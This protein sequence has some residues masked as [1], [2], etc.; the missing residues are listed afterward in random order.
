MTQGNRIKR[1][2]QKLNPNIRSA[3]ISTTRNSWWSNLKIGSKYLVVMG[4]ISTLLLITASIVFIRLAAIH[5]NVMEMD[6]RSEE[7]IRLTEMGS[8]FRA[9]SIQG[10][11]YQFSPDEQVLEQFQETMERLNSF[12]DYLEPLMKTAEEKE[13]FARLL[14]LDD[15]L[16]SL[17]YDMLVPFVDQNDEHIVMTTLRQFDVLR[18][19]Y[20]STLYEL[21]GKME[22]ERHAATNDTYWELTY[23]SIVLIIAFIVTLVIGVSSIV[24]INKLIRINLRNVVEQANY[25]AD[26]DLSH[27]N[28]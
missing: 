11:D 27:E 14:V 21:R 25:I 1:L 3:S 23:R 7:S 28:L 22:D 6:N 17:F 20:I 24:I 15:R 9:K 10:Y 19:E 18:N 2:I 16:N 8:I 13:L 5:D 4:I 12:E 26:G